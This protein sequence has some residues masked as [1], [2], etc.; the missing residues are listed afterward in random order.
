MK[1]VFTT[2]VPARPKNFP[3]N[4]LPAA[5]RSRQHRVECALFDFLRDQ[6][7]ADEDGDHHAEQRHRGEA[8]V[9][10]HQAL[11]VD[12][13][14]SHENGRAGKQQGESDQVIE[15][16]VANRFAKRVRGNVNDARAHDGQVSPRRFENAAISRRNMLRAKC[17]AG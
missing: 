15:N 6:P 14:L 1:N 5:D 4:E 7:D 8:E 13:N 12:G 16:A 3:D 9:D 10:D 11:D 17:A 2:S